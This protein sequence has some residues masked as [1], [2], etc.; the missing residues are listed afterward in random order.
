[1][2]KIKSPSDIAAKIQEMY[3]DQQRIERFSQNSRKLAEDKFNVKNIVN[4]HAKIY[5]KMIGAQGRT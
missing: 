1:M 2:V 4:E 5:E 3:Q